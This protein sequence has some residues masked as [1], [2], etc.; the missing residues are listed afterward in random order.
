MRYSVVLLWVVALGFVHPTQVTVAGQKPVEQRDIDFVVPTAD[1]VR[2][3]AGQ[4]DTVLTI[5]I[6]S[7]SSALLNEPGTRRDHVFTTYH[8]EVLEQHKRHPL[9][10]PAGTELQFGQRGGEVD[11]GD[12]IIRA[13]GSGLLQPMREYVV[14]LTRNP[15]FDI[16]ELPWGAAGALEI[17]ENDVKPAAHSAAGAAL[18]KMGKARLLAELRSL[19]K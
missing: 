16:W 10:V 5:R 1:S 2:E 19:E 14:F 11:A 18:E 13:N 17:R 3:L 8:A 9:G 4:A 15:A 7:R 6:R 12:R